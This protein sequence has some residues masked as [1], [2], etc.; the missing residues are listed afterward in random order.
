MRLQGQPADD[1]TA[2]T[3]AAWVEALTFRRVWDEH[4]D[5]PRIRHAFK[6]LAST[7]RE[8]PAPADLVQHLP[9]VE[10]Q[11]ALPER[12]VDLEKAKATIAECMR[13]LYGGR[14]GD[15]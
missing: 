3:I 7:C 13:L 11:L 5:A 1:M 8:W 6:A 9:P 15:D 4:R 14:H 10:A 12:P 2:G